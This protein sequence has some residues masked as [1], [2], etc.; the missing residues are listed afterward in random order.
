MSTSSDA[1]KKLAD[2]INKVMKQVPE[3]VPADRDALEELVFSLLLYNNTSARAEEA[4]QKLL[5]GTIDYNDLRVTLTEDLVNLIGADFPQATER[6]DRIRASL[7]EIYT[8]Q[9][10]VTLKPASELSKRDARTYLESLPGMNPFAAARVLLLCFKGHAIP[11]DEQMLSCLIEEGVFEADTKL[12]AAQSFL[13]RHIKASNSIPTYLQLQY[14]AEHYHD[15]QSNKKANSKS[16]R[17]K[18]KTTTGTAAD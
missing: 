15:D 9:Y 17:G 1:A 14:W 18:K 6:I 10:E 8:R 13:E 16:S 11:L 12:H 2:L 4:L 7:S 5:E 3:V